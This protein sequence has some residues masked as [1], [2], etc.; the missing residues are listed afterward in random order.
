MENLGNSSSFLKA[1][2]QTTSKLGW[3][4]TCRFSVFKDL[5]EKEMGIEKSNLA[6]LDEKGVDITTMHNDEVALSD[7]KRQCHV[8][9]QV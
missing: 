1:S 3:S 2:K 6:I 8:S 4:H 9:F 7:K 5:V